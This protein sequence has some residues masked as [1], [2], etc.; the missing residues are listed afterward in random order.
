[1]HGIVFGLGSMGKRRIRCLSELGF[2]DIIG[3]DPREDRRAEVEK[4]YR[5]KTVSS[6]SELDLSGFQYAIISTPPHMHEEY[7]KICVEAGIHFFVEASVIDGSLGQIGEAADRKGLVAAPSATLLFHPAIQKI[8]ET[9]S[10]GKLGRITNY[11]YHSGQYLPDWHPYE[12]V[13]D[14][15]VSR[16]ETGGAR[17]IV[18]FELSW[19]VK[20]FGWP[21]AVS[22][23]VLK[24]SSIPGAEDIDDTFTFL[25]LH[26]GIIGTMV[27]DVISRFATRQMTI[28]GTEAQLTWDWNDSAIKVYYGREQ[29]WEVLDYPR[30][31]AAS[32]YNQNISERM[33]VEEVNEFLQSC[34]K[35]AKFRNTLREDQKVLSILRGIEESAYRGARVSL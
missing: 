4:N 12:H 28:V 8:I 24:T 31:Q 13:Q 27:V 17:E 25:I 9:V 22:A 16:R 5:V 7:M 1:M 23:E 6:L 33:Y 19:L 10:S 15:Y 2:T 29:R 14:Y 32:G 35:A 34:L 21:K 11:I 18:P 3:L 26:D 30:Y 20:C